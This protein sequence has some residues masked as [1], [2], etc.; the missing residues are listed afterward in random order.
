M[1]LSFFYPYLSWF[2]IIPVAFAHLFK[3]SKK[4]AVGALGFLIPFLALQPPSF[5]KFQTAL[6]SS[7]LFRS[8]IHGQIGEFTPS[9]LSG[10]FYL[11]L[12]GF[13]IM[14]PKFSIRTRKLN[15]ASLL[16]LIYL[17]PGLQY[18]R[19]YL[20]LILPLF[21][22]CYAREISILL[23]KP[24]QDLVSDWRNLIYNAVIVRLRTITRWRPQQGASEAKESDDDRFSK[25]RKSLIAA[26]YLVVL[27]YLVQLNQGLL[28]G[29]KT[30]REGL[31][32]VPES[33]LIISSFPLQYKTL[34]V[35]PDLRIIPSCELGFSSPEIREEYEAY[36]NEGLVV[37]LMEKTG[38]QYLI[39]NRD[40]E[41]DPQEG[42]RL[43]RVADNDQVRVWKL[44]ENE[45][46]TEE[47][48]QTE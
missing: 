31:K 13:L 20:D 19:Y 37:P 23:K 1:T 10:H 7:G 17:V 24:L 35:R 48:M 3:G 28:S 14:Y 15:C 29:L 9:F 34:L 41:I 21:F 6:F 2:Y 36:F 12:A 26:A 40:V 4:F 30:F 38:V 46:R 47:T 39:E 5:W 11:V 42:N 16:L 45:T 32:D 27:L 43:E 18:I 44:T 25:L 22:V 8:A 33:T